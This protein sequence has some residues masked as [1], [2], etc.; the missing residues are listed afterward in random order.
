MVGEMKAW[1]SRDISRR[2]HHVCN[3]CSVGAGIQKADRVE[4]AG[5]HPRCP[6][7]ANRLMFNRCEF[8]LLDA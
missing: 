3:N 6:E 2:V 1:H 5:I 8:Q 7:C 4:G